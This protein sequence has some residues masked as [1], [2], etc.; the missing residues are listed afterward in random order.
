MSHPSRVL[1]AIAV[2]LGVAA[3]WVLPAQAAGLDQVAIDAR[4]SPEGVLTVTETITVSSGADTIFQQI[5]V[6]VDRDG[7]RYSY[8]LSDISVGGGNGSIGFQSES[9]DYESGMVEWS[10]IDSGTGT[11]TL[12]YTV[13]GTTAR[14]VDGNTDFTFIL[15]GG[16]NIDVAQVTGSVAVPPGAIN[17]DCSAGFP[18]ALMKCST[19]TA[20]THGNTTLEFTNNAVSGGQVVQAQIVFTPDA[21]AVTEN[22][23]AIWTLG[24]ALTAG[25]AQ[26]GTMAAI[27]VVGGLILFGVWRR[28]RLSGYKGA[29]AAIARF[30]ADAGG[31]VTFSA[32]PTV[33]PGMVG[34]LVD[35]SVDPADIVST[36]LDLAV[37]GHLL[38]TEVPTS[39]YA[40][41]DWTFT[42]LPDGVDE[43]KEYELEL[44][45]ALTTSEVSVS[46][47]SASVSQ[48]I[49]K[50]QGA[51]YQEVVSAGWFSRLPSKRSPMVTWAWVLVGVAVAATAVLMAFTTFG[52]AGLGLAA[53][54][55]VGV[56]LAYQARP[57][58][59]AGAAVYA[60]LGELAGELHTH[61]GSEIAPGE[62]YTQISRILPYAVVLGSW[63]QWLGSMVAADEDEA[64][65][66]TD[67]TWYHAPDDWHMS[68]FPASLDSFITVVTGRLFTRT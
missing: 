37:R 57:I 19:Y 25:W 48:A 26:I 59:P 45:N 61:S 53:V 24:R 7:N 6:S 4:L 31:H 21:M 41:S 50:V 47:L 1:A 43:L 27:L 30:S 58:T 44:L 46:G 13:R 8:E 16:L 22:A 17:Y 11:L 68:D 32:D 10:G 49:E 29:P 66:S 62:R 12:S 38:I 42:R 55:I 3:G 28:G 40:T 39:R 63:D 34:T 51:L 60:G 23:S 20:G 36:I 35:S 52:L 56:A 65:D 67:L 33:R 18:G 54:A 14:A 2:A 64:A 5:P 9:V 15:L